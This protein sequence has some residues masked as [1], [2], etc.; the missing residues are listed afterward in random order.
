MKKLFCLML[1]VALLS[2]PTLPGLAEAQPQDAPDPGIARDLEALDPAGDLAE[3]P[4]LEDTPDPN[5]TPAPERVVDVDGQFTFVCPGAL[6]PIPIDQQ[7]IGD[8]LLYSAYSDTMGVDVYKYPQGDDTLQS[9][10]DAYKADDNMS[11]VALADVGG[12]KVLVYRIDDTGIDAT[13][14]GDTGFLY[15]IMFNYQSPEEYQ[16][17]GQMIAS[18]KKAGA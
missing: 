1:A 13:V 17:L 4:L 6:S 14:Q 5:A 10:Y 11:E 18:L 15:D 12:V 2:G 3:D 8:G 9:L 7:D 16:L